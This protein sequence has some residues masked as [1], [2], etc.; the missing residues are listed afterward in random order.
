MMNKC[1]H[2]DAR[3]LTRDNIPL[4]FYLCVECRNKDLLTKRRHLGDV[5]SFVRVGR[6]SWEHLVE[7]NC[8]PQ[9]L[10]LLGKLGWELV[11]VINKPSVNPIK[12]TA[13]I[14]DEKYI[15]KRPGPRTLKRSFEENP[16]MSDTVLLR[17]TVSDPDPSI[18]DRTAR[19][20]MGNSNG[21]FEPYQD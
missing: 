1:S 5:L 6:P 3:V 2:C 11:T 13:G 21:N 10:L 20:L 15:F 18:L 9:R 7:Y 12:Q 17:S 19:G 14:A 8:K 16:S 4:K